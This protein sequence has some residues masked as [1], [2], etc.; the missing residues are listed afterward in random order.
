[1]PVS[2]AVSRIQ[3]MIN[4]A[5]KPSRGQHSRLRSAGPATRGG[6]HRAKRNAAAT[7]AVTSAGAKQ[8]EKQRANRM[9]KDDIG[10]P[11]PFARDRAKMATQERVE[12]NATASAAAAVDG[13]AD[14]P[15]VDRL[16]TP[17]INRVEVRKGSAWGSLSRRWRLVYS[18]HV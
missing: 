17:V 16:K 11:R 12:R 13:G 2:T 5:Q 3:E 10:V 15:K 8:N 4:L 7:A 9:G 1:M 18:P 14:P 6:G